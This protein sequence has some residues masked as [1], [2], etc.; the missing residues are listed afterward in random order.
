MKDRLFKKYRVEVEDYNMAI[1]H[2]KLTEDPEVER[3]LKEF[4]AQYDESEKQR[5]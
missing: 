5:L 4:E 1:A 2:H 3:M